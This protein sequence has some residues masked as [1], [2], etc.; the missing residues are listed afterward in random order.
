[1]SKYHA[2]LECG[3]TLRLLYKAMRKGVGELQR[4]WMHKA[5]NLKRLSPPMILQV[6][7]VGLPANLAILSMPAFSVSIWRGVNFLAYLI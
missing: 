1:M 3:T 6:N 4:G 5:S 7:W 2:S